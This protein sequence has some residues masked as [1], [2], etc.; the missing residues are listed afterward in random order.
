MSCLLVRGGL[1][2]TFLVCRRDLNLHGSGIECRSSGHGV[3]GLW[4]AYT[5]ASFESQ[6]FLFVFLFLARPG[7]GRVSTTAVRTSYGIAEFLWGVFA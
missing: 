2:W 6:S 5:L 4:E 7:V 3:S 1:A